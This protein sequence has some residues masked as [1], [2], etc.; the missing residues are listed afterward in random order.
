MTSGPLMAANVCG[1]LVADR[2]ALPVVVA[3]TTEAIISP[4]TMKVSPPEPPLM[5]VTALAAV[6]S[7]LIVSSPSRASSVIDS[8]F[9]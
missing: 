2:L 1:L 6:L 8:R 7:T 5:I 4:A 3:E 9:A